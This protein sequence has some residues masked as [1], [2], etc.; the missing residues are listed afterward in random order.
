EFH[1]LAEHETVLTPD[2]N[3]H[4]AGEQVHAHRLRPPPP[5]EQVG[6]GPR[7]EYDARWTVESAGDDELT[8]GL[9]FHSCALLHG[10]GLTLSS[11]VHRISPSV[12]NPRRLCP[13][14]RS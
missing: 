11:C 2:T 1:T 7:F 12:S 8:L 6:L 9:P 5:L 4:L 14:R 10:R 3:I 13:T